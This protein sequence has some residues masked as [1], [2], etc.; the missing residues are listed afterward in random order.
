MGTEDGPQLS[1][2]WCRRA[3]SA[4]AVKC[5]HCGREPRPQGLAPL[6][7]Y[8]APVELSTPPAVEESAVTPWHAI[9][10][11]PPR[12][13]LAEL[14]R[15]KAE[16]IAQSAKWVKLGYIEYL[17]HL[18]REDQVFAALLG[19]MIIQLVLSFASLAGRADTGSPFVISGIAWVLLQSVMVWGILA[20]QRWAHTV[21][22]WSAGISI[23]GGLLGSV[24]LVLAPLRT[25]S[26]LELFLIWVQWILGI[27]GGVFVLV[28]LSERS[29]YFDGTS[30][31]VTPKRTR[32]KD[33]LK[34]E[35]WRQLNAPRDYE[36][37]APP[38]RPKQMPTPQPSAV[39]TPRGD[40]EGLRPFGR[41]EAK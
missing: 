13:P 18:L 16:K 11:A 37:S 9:P 7:G 3:V 6:G 24:S 17:K 40:L 25:D 5:S 28:V 32:L 33:F 27:A 22:I 10:T 31:R 1:C 39:Y 12:D 35:Y 15:R 21:L 41:D 34:R 38:S 23:I 14:E 36:A 26:V 4:E 19:L 8:L 30:A 2:A 29:A 20:L